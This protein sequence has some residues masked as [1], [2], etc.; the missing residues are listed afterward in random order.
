MKVLSL[1]LVILIDASCF[2]APAPDPLAT[3]REAVWNSP[4]MLQARGWLTQ[5]FAASKKHS[6]KDAQQYL[7]RL[8]AATPEQMRSWLADFYARRQRQVVEQ[9]QAGAQ[10]QWAVSNTFATQ[11]AQQQ[12]LAAQQAAAAVQA[13]AL[14]AQLEAQRAAMQLYQTQPTPNWY[15]DRTYGFSN[16]TLAILNFLDTQAIREELQQREQK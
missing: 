11:R 9:Q 13:R 12:Q 14:Q 5:Y 7:D 2:A 16:R 3:E 8:H 10:R 1:L 15:D 6:K 4:E